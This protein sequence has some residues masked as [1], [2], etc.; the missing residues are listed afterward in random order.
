MKQYTISIIFILISGVNFFNKSDN[1]IILL[2]ILY[3]FFIVLFYQLKLKFDLKLIKKQK[4][5]KVKTSSVYGV[6]VL[7][8][9]ITLS[10]YYFNRR[11]TDEHLITRL[12]LYL[13][14]ICFFAEI[15]ASFFMNLFI[16]TPG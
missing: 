12:V 9:Y 2:L 11:L 5:T 13:F 14:E 8:I 7:L 10:I 4:T 15:A 16:D 6:L 3:A 1:M